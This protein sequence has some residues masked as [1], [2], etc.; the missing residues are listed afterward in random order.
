MSSKCLSSRWSN[1]VSPLPLSG[2]SSSTLSLHPTSPHLPLSPTLLP[3]SSPTQ[4]FPQL[5]SIVVFGCISDK[6]DGE[7][8]GRDVCY[9]N[10]SNNSN[11]CSFGVAVGVIGFLFCLIFLVKDVLYVVVDFSNNLMVGTVCRLCTPCI[12]YT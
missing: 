8:G 4:Y 2:V 7:I 12:Y 5:C 11:A 1:N 9:Y 6:V 10:Y 3:S